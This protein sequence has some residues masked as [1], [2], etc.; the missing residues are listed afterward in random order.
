MGIVMCMAKR[1]S[2]HIH[3]SA[4]TTSNQTDCVSNIAIERKML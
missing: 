1:E 2:A 3:D 4:L